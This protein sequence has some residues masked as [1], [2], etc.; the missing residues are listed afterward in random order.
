[1]GYMSDVTIVVYSLEGSEVPFAALK[2]WVQDTFPLREAEQQWGAEVGF[3]DDM[4]CMEIRYTSV[5]WY[6]DFPHV[7]NVNEALAR[8]Q[9]DFPRRKLDEDHPHNGAPLVAWEMGVIGENY[10]DA[11]VEGS[12]DNECRMGIRREIYFD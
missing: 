7:Q 9:D 1:M 5:K 10:D 4:G 2:L 6:D 12:E 8:L 11:H 3:H